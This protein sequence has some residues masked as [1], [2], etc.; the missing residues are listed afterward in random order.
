VGLIKHAGGAKAPPVARRP[1][2]PHQDRWRTCRD[3]ETPSPV[4]SARTPQRPWART[5]SRRRPPR[6]YLRRAR[7]RSRR[8]VWR[9][10]LRAAIGQQT[11][12]TAP[13]NHASRSGIVAVGRLNR[14]DAAFIVV[15]LATLEVSCHAG[16][17]GFESRRSRLR[18]CLQ[19]RSFVVSIGA[20]GVLPGSSRAAASGG[21]RHELPCKYR[22]L[23]ASHPVRG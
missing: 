10:A 6:Q 5:R 9:G 4:L 11:P 17:R 18:I 12:R 22:R 8:Q 20:G 13:L 2:E 3:A 1:G 14:G 21:F 23:R 19:M 16:G 15:H 7:P